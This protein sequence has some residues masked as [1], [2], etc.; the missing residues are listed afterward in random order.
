MSAKIIGPYLMNLLGREE[1]EED[2]SG[3]HGDTFVGRG[4]GGRGG[5]RG[6]GGRGARGGHHG[7][8]WG[9]GFS[10]GYVLFEPHCEIE[11]VISEIETQSNEDEKEDKE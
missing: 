11:D 10:D 7:G 1:R 4:G 2:L 8:R 9:R 6:G 5:G 3:V